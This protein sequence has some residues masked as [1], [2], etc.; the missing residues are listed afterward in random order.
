MTL[1]SA[2][3][4]IDFGSAALAKAGVAATLTTTQSSLRPGEGQLIE[5]TV[6]AGT[7][8]GGPGD[9]VVEIDFEPRH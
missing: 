5:V 3:T 1:Q 6:T 8:T 9:L 7:C 2:A 4:D